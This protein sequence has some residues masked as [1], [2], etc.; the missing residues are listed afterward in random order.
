M[1]AP[2]RKLTRRLTQ[3]AKLLENRP[4][5]SAE[6][7]MHAFGFS[8]ESEM[9]RERLAASAER[10]VVT[11]AV[12][13]RRLSV[14]AFFVFVALPGCGPKPSD[15]V[16]S[17]GI[18]TDRMAQVAAQQRSPNWCWAASIQMVLSTKGIRV[19]QAD[20]VRQTYGQLVD[21]PG[22]ADAII[23]RLSG[24]FQTRSGNVLLVTSVV[25]GPL[26]E[27]LLYSYLK[28][29]SPLILGF[30][31]PGMNVGH[32]VVVTAAIF[33]MSDVGLE[34]LEV[35][36]RDPWP[37]FAGQKGKRTLTREEFANAIFYCVVDVVE[38]P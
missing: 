24:W 12:N 22:D 5:R 4:T 2:P 19:D 8:A 23:N 26:Q 20:V 21:A 11:C 32:A 6:S 25:P 15:H 33:R 29:Q 35:V 37:D 14:V 13:Q 3:P 27:G 18:P 28:N 7:Q 16:F 34:L 9:R 10:S 17:V 31:N 1:V 36:V 38:K 30:S